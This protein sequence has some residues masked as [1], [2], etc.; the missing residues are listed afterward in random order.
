MQHIV[1]KNSSK[2]LFQVNGQ[3]MLQH[4][5]GH[6]LLNL[7]AGLRMLGEYLP[8]FLLVMLQCVCLSQ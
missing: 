5:V 6:C 8:C 3:T 4:S 7:E 2:F 1:R